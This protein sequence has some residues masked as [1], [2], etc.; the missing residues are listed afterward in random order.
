M[1]SQEIT[2]TTPKLIS[3]VIPAFNEEL[4]VWNAYER[5]KEVFESALKDYDFEII[6]TDNHSTDGTY[7]ELEKIARKDSRVKVA[8]FARNYG[9]NNSLITGYR[10]AKGHAAIQLDCDLQDPPSLFPVFIKKWESGHDVVVGLRPKR[11]EPALLLLARKFFYRFL[12]RISEDNLVVDGGDFRLV[13]RSILDQLREIHDATPYVRGLVSTLAAN[14]TSFEYERSKRAHGKSKFPVIRLLGL[15]VEGIINHSTVPLR[16]ATIF[17][18]L[19]ATLAVLLSLGYFVARLVF[20][21]FMP[22]GFATTVIL[23]LLSIGLNGIFLG[24]IGEY[25]GHIHR[26]L[27]DRP[28]T[29]IQRAINLTDLDMKYVKSARTRGVP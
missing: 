6:F 3:I 12:S 18:L 14:Q 16:L 9:F 21:D 15:A 28:V 10:L 1:N 8:R 7:V 27:R 13:D 25:L 24:I 17:G 22:A 11:Q 23:E 29:V 19:I 5:T 20:V 2:A 26:Q 4:N